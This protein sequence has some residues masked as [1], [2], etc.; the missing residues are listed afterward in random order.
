MKGGG[1]GKLAEPKD[2]Q[3]N[4]FV[5]FSE[6]LVKGCF[7]VGGDVGAG[8]G[9]FMFVFSGGGGR[10]NDGC[11]GR[12]RSGCVHVIGR[13]HADAVTRMVIAVVVMTCDGAAVAVEEL[14]LIVI[15]GGNRASGGAVGIVFYISVHSMDECRWSGIVDSVSANVMMTSS[16]GTGK[17]FVIGVVVGCCCIVMSGERATVSSRIKVGC[18]FGYNFI[19]KWGNFAAE[20]A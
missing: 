13:A 6:P 19:L 1:K 10:R 15:S 11:I 18:S 20:I 8:S 16:C 5:I 9:I 3:R 14:R 7:G 2:F 4:P 12:L 17:G